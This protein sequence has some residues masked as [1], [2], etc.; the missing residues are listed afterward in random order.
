MK[1]LIFFLLLIIY[2]YPSPELRM[3]MFNILTVV[4]AFSLLIYGIYMYRKYD[5]EYDAK[6]KEEYFQKIPAQRTPVELSYLLYGKITPN[7]VTSTIMN[8]IRKKILKLHRNNNDYILSYNDGHSQSL[9]PS[10]S[11]LINWLIKTM[12][13]MNKIAVSSIEAK[14]RLDSDYFHSLYKEW[15][16]N[17]MV[18]G[19]RQSFFEKREN[20][21]QNAYSFI[22]LALLLIVFNI[23][24]RNHWLL[25]LVIIVGAT[26][27]TIYVYNLNKR[28]IEANEEYWTWLAFKRY[29]NH[30][31]HFDLETDLNYLEDCAI[32]ANIFKQLDDYQKL[33]NASFKDNLN[34]IEDNNLL[35][36]IVNGDILVINKA[37]EN[38]LSRAFIKESILGR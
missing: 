27:F 14:C 34:E 4:W 30:I 32:Y 25:I 31:K 12:G 38:C 8:L 22:S 5:K 35:S 19:L 23:L 20:I 10:E 7:C 16:S 6:I 1:I 37:I 3:M 21:S 26:I 33:L 9:E 24:I 29:L 28:T 15:I 13:H 36:T 18:E 11:F 17:A 2:Y